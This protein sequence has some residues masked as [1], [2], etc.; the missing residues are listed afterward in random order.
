MMKFQ[1][2]YQAKTLE[3][4]RELMA[5]FPTSSASVER[6]RASFSAS[7]SVLPSFANESAFKA[8]YGPTRITPNIVSTFG[9]PSD[10]EG[11]FAKLMELMDSGKVVRGYQ[12]TGLKWN[13][14]SMF[15]RPPDDEGEAG[16]DFSGIDA[17]DC[18]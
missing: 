7:P 3:E 17:D 14:G 16:G 15:Q 1:I 11:Q 6:P 10:R 2:T 18:V 13:D 5:E 12:G 9:L 4:F 8:E